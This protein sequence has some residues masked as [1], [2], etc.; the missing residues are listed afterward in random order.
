MLNSRD[1]G[2][3]R[4]DVA[5]NCRAMTA[6]AKQAGYDVLVTGTVRDDEYQLDCYNKGYS[7]AKT[8]SFH[9]VKA[10]LAFD[11]CKNV[12][13]HEYDDN[14]FWK[15]VSAIGKGL[16]FTWGGDWT[17]ITDKPHFQW[18]AH[19]KYTSTMIRA[20]QY[21]AE[22]PI[23]EEDDD[24]SKLTDEE[25]AEYMKRYLSVTGTGDVPSDWAKDA[26]AAMK[27]AGAFHGDGN[28]NYGWQKPITR[29]AVAVAL[30]NGVLT[31]GANA[32]G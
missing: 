20:G 4:S 30:H 22:M 1:I 14:A 21:P 16:G 24:M 25:F 31:G 13:G 10:G 7:N 27:S 18:D 11:I 6:L 29:E 8:P 15:A 9:S 19:G 26:T 28:G 23:Y 2:L 32:D 12:K 5:A 3:L 17:S